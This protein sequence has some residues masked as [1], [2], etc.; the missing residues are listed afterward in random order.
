MADH[1]GITLAACAPYFY[2]LDGSVELKGRCQSLW[3][4]PIDRQAKRVIGDASSIQSLG[5][6]HRGPNT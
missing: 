6:S 4:H 1:E 5:R 3:G 2:V